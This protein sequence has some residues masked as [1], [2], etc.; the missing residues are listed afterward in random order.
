MIM[1]S[2][3]GPNSTL[4]LHTE[5]TLPYRELTLWWKWGWDGASKKRGQ[6]PWGS[7]LDKKREAYDEENK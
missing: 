1:S 5:L 3:K 7:V 6:W 2:A 4:E